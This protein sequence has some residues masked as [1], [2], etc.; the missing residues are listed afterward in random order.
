MVEVD[1][2]RIVDIVF[3]ALLIDLFAFTIILPLFPR[4]LS[5]YQNQEAGHQVRLFFIKQVQYGSIF[6]SSV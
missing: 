2:K 6:N 5:Y 3:K 4:L 1:Q